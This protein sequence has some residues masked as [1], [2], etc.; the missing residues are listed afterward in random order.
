MC[1]TNNSGLLDTELNGTFDCRLNVRRAMSEKLKAPPESD[2][3]FRG[4]GTRSHRTQQRLQ[5]WGRGGVTELEPGTIGIAL[6]AGGGSS[7]GLG[8]QLELTARFH[9]ELVC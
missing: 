8:Q 3:M 2:F 5:A 4:L 7:S 6:G 1:I 9:E